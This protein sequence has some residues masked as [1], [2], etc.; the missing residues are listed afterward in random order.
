MPAGTPLQKVLTAVR[1]LALDEFQGQRR[2]AMVLHTDELHPPM[3]LV[4]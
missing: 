1:A 3:H 2:Y 4:L